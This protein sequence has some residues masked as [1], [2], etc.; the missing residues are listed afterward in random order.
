ML[1]P[2]E[3]FTAIL[4]DKAIDRE[5]RERVVQ[6]LVDAHMLM[7]DRALGAQRR[8]I[9]DDIHDEKMRHPGAPLA[10]YAGMNQA[11]STVRNDVK[12]GA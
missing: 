8:Q 9:A 10:F 4:A 5:T 2:K 11:A 1:T 7:L 12:A 6:V 3:R